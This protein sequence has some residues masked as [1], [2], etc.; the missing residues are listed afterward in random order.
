MDLSKRLE[1]KV[2]KAG[3]YWPNKTSEVRYDNLLQN[4]ESAWQAL[5]KVIQQPVLLLVP[6]NCAKVLNHL[7]S[8]ED[9][10]DGVVCAWVGTK[11]LNSEVESFGDDKGAIWVPTAQP[12]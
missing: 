9:A 2:S 11:Y 12:Q 3:K 5:G 8:Y 1:Y 10:L 6:L 4:I 7:K